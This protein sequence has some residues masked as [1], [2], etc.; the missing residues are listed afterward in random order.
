[1]VLCVL[2]FYAEGQQSAVNEKAHGCHSRQDDVLAT[3][4]VGLCEGHHHRQVG[5]CSDEGAEKDHPRLLTGELVLQ[6]DLISDWHLPFESC[7]QPASRL[8]F[9]YIDF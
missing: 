3:V 9:S 5:A 4:L 8:H 7:G 2:V 6:D 1:M